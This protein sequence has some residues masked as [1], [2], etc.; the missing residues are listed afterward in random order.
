MLTGVGNF[1]TLIL[2]RSQT[3][4]NVSRDFISAFLFLNWKLAA[5]FIN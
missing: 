3:H 4:T 5:A 2:L 1:P